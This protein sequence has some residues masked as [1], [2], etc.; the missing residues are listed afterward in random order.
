MNEFFGSPLAADL[1]GSL[2]MLLVGMLI[3][4]NLAHRRAY[5]D[6]Y[7]AGWQARKTAL[8]AAAFK[9]QPCTREPNRA[10]L[11]PCNGAFC[12][13]NAEAMKQAARDW[14]KEKGV[15]T[16]HD[17]DMSRAEVRAY[18]SFVPPRDAY[19]S[20]CVNTCEAAACLES[21]FCQEN[22]KAWR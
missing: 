17:M 22:G 13:S 20:S 11:G 21:G 15:G 14:A 7:E 8:Y 10:H 3:G 6:G 5:W 18:E 9:V 4:N 19:A 1:F 12:G 16:F 2:A